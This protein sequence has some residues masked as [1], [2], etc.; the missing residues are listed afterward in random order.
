MTTYIRP[1]CCSNDAIRID[2]PQS[3]VMEDTTCCT[4][5]TCNAPTT[6]VTRC[7]TCKTTP[8]SCRTTTTKKTCSCSSQPTL[9]QITEQ[10]HCAPQYIQVP[11]NLFVKNTATFVMPACGETVTIFIENAR[12]L[13]VGAYLF[14]QTVGY[15]KISTI[16]DDCTIK[17]ELT[18]E[19]CDNN[20]N[21]ASPGSSVAGCTEFIITAL[22][23]TSATG[24]G[25]LSLTPCLTTCFYSPAEEGTVTIGVSYIGNMV[26]GSVVTI[27]GYNYTVVTIVN[28]E[29]IVIRN[30]GEGA[31]T[32]TYFDCDDECNYPIT[33]VTN[34]SPCENDPVTSGVIVVCDGSE[35]TTLQGNIDNQIPVWDN[36][37]QKFVLEVLE[38]NTID[39]TTLTACLILDPAFPTATHIIEVADSSIFEKVEYEQFENLLIYINGD[40]FTVVEVIDGTH[41]RVKPFFSFVDII[42]YE[43]GD[44]VCIA[45]CCEQ[46][47]PVIETMGRYGGQEGEPSEELIVLQDLGISIPDG[48]SVRN[49]YTGVGLPTPAATTDATIAPPTDDGLYDIAYRNDGACKKYFELT[50][51]CACVLDI[52]TGVLANIEFRTGNSDGDTQSFAAIPVIGNDD[53]GIADPADVG[54]VSAEQPG[55]LFQSSLKDLNTYK[56]MLYDRDFVDPAETIHFYGHIRLTFKNTTGA[57]VAANFEANIRAWYKAWDFE[58]GPDI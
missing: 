55:N 26:S 34:P 46:C 52:P 23:C 57:P 53:M 58:L 22:G 7:T 25:I 56:C 39:C 45:D 49:Y 18:Q 44:V 13:S 17:A 54:F 6:T 14:A 15:L 5:G 1:S 31:P 40:P 10:Q 12:R 42:E 43:V 9:V 3:S 27:G 29:T 38:Q 8:C 48:V 37:L 32:N 11:G 2:S 16:V 51:N 4:T 24:G 28:S 21:I 36:D 20:C 47:K 30:D 19:I 50:S 35:Q 41:V 33:V